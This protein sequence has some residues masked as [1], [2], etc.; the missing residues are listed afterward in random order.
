MAV[1]AL[2]TTLFALAMLGMAVGV[3]LS[4]RRLHGSCGGTGG[5]CVCE[6]EKRRACHALKQFER[7]GLRSGEGRAQLWQDK[8]AAQP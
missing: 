6:I 3:V 2:T 4:N 1:V 5:D 7:S 8:P